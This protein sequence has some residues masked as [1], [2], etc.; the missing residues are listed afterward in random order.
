MLLVDWRS[1]A[2]CARC[3]FTAPN[4]VSPSSA[5]GYGALLGR[6]TEAHPKCDES[7]CRK[8]S[9]DTLRERDPLFPPGRI[10]DT[11]TIVGR[12]EHR[13]EHLG[14]E[15]SDADIPRGRLPQGA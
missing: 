6:A 1:P 7:Q 2:G 13:L 11:A 8:T 5:G 4:D 12:L 3:R 15:Q 14:R 9:T 10:T